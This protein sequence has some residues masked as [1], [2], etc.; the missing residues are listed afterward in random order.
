MTDALVEQLH[1]IST[2]RGQDPREACGPI[3]YPSVSQLQRW[4]DTEGDRVVSIYDDEDGSLCGAFLFDATGFVKNAASK[5]WNPPGYDPANPSPK[6]VAYGQAVFGWIEEAV[7][8]PVKV[9][10]YNPRFSEVVETIGF[11]ATRSDEQAP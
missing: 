7:G 6:G 3:P 11:E 10:T 5:P 8:G 9:Y 1:A 4:L 2:V